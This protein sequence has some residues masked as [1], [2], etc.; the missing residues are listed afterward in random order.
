VTIFAY[1][2]S[3]TTPGAAGWSVEVSSAIR[4][5]SITGLVAEAE[6][7]AVGAGNIVL[8]D[9]TSSIGHSSDGVVGLK[10]FHMIET[11][12]PSG[13][14][15]LFT[16]YIGDRRYHRGTSDSLITGA[17]RVID[18]TLYD[19]NSF[20]AF[21]VF[22][23]VK[24]DATSSFV[25]PAE[26]DL[27]R[28][29]ALLTNV[30]FLSDTLF[31]IGYIP[32]TGGILMDANDYTGSH[33]GDVLNSCAQASGRNYFVLYD[34]ATGK[35]VLWYDKWTTDG[36]ATIVYDSPLSLTNVLSE[37]SANAAILLT[38]TP[39]DT[40]VTLAWYVG[41][42][43]TTFII[44]PDAVMTLDPSRVVSAVYLPYTGGTAYK[45][46]PGTAHT[47]AWRDM[48][49]PSV[50]VKSL[51]KANAL[52]DRYL[53]DN[54]TEDNRLTLTVQ[55]PSSAVTLLREG[56]RVQV[57]AT[58]L[59]LVNG[60]FTWCR[61]LQ[62][63][64]RMDQDTP[65]YYWIDL[66]LS[67][68]T[69]TC[70]TGSVAYLSDSG[71]SLYTYTPIAATIPAASATL[72]TFC[73]INGPWDYLGNDLTVDGAWTM[74]DVALTDDLPRGSL[75]YVRDIAGVAYSSGASSATFG[76]PGVYVRRG[77]GRILG[78]AINTAATAP[79][80]FAHS[81][82]L[83]R[84]GN[85]TLPGAPTAGNILVMCEVTKWNVTTA[86]ISAPT[87]W[88]LV[89]SARMDDTLTDF[90]SEGHGSAYL[91]HWQVSICMRC[92][93]AGETTSL[94]VGDPDSNG[95]YTFISEWPLA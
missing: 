28:I 91:P 11:D 31:D 49:A 16:G 23:P 70:S 34:E 6:A 15:R 42:G 54:S 94:Y 77:V 80:Q 93:G 90:S 92:V 19:I 27:A 22:A 38:A 71:D 52:A 1:Y 63:T 83:F 50:A 51:A 44:E 69:F 72:L 24:L 26:T 32:D 82:E 53:M 81:Y 76:W 67:V 65:F 39:G 18:A 62:R 57:H 66:E 86:A 46:L 64:I 25:R 13:Q 84:S 43:G 37:A 55:L 73:A 56:M 30:D 33:P 59:P 78:A 61:V 29:A 68:T 36:T 5:A 3:P 2:T 95:H 89:A 79:V 75:D 60:G 40:E 7:G 10:Q 20:L 85:F 9:P 88:V 35:Y 8:D 58:H 17:A 21:R 47:F 74:M 45:T 12:G 48:V 14:Q 41:T 4:L 87:G